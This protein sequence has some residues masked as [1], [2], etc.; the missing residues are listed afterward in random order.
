M[1]GSS[2]I[3]KVCHYNKKNMVTWKNWQLLILESL[4]HLFI[5]F[6]LSNGLHMELNFHW[7]PN[8]NHQIRI[9]RSC[10]IPCTDTRTT[11]QQILIS[12]KLKK[13]LKNYFCNPKTHV[14][15]MNSYPTYP[16]TKSKILH[17]HNWCN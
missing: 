1:N 7:T 9:F 8:Q 14:A 4:T 13:P 6:G 16:K 11:F 2:A 17:H 15:T 5:F 3:L 12:D 10:S